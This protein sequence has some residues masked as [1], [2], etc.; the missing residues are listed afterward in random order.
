M[1]LTKIDVAEAHLRASIRMFFEDAHPV[2]IY[3]LGCAAREILDKLGR[4]LKVPTILDDIARWRG[5]NVHELKKK[6]TRFNNFMKHADRDPT[7]V[8]EDFSDL[9][10][11]VLLF[12][13]TRDYHQIAK[14]LPIEAQIFEA[15]FF[16]TK[17]KRI[18]N[19]GIRWQQKVRSCIKHFPGIR[20]ASRAKQKELGLNALNVAL[21]N[22]SLQMEMKKTVELPEA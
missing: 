14:G 6:V 15:W 3:T 16:A 2:P 19:G 8:L 11:D 10:N 17:V 7:D 20:S 12:Y 5:A 9:D 13:A 22:P 4:K 18:S 1:R 21:A